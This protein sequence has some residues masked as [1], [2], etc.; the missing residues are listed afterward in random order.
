MLFSVFLFT[1][2]PLP[3]IQAQMKKKC[4]EGLL[5]NLLVEDEVHHSYAFGR[6][7]TMKEVGVFL[8]GALEFADAFVL[9][10]QDGVGEHVGSMEVMFAFFHDGVDLV[11]NL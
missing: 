10:V 9:L 11:G 5:Q 2:H 1:P 4:L 8:N 3:S 6:V 7:V